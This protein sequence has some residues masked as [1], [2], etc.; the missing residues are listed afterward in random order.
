MSH[1]RVEVR[2]FF[3]KK[4]VFFSSARDFK[5]FKL[6]QNYQY[7]SSATP[8]VFVFVFDS[9]L[10]LCSWIRARP[11]CTRRRNNVRTASANRD[12]VCTRTEYLK[13][14]MTRFPRKMCFI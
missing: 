5:N 2:L 7:P 4:H 13:K 12:F 9:D 3:L 11:R 1:F 10:S 14:Q 6:M 8:L